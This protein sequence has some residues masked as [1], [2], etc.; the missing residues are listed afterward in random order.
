MGKATALRRGFERALAE[1]ADVVVMM[2]ADGQDDPAELPLLLARLEDGADL[3][4]GARTVRHDRFVK[5]HTS[6]LYNS[7]HRPALRRPGQGLQLRLQGDARRRRAQRRA[8]DVRRAAPLPHRRRALARLPDRRGQR[9]AP[10]A[11]ARAHQVRPG[12]LLARL[13]RP[14]HGPVPD[15]LR[16]P[17]LAPV[18]RH[19]PGQP[20]PRRRGDGLPAASRSSSGDPI[21]GRPLLIAAVVLALGGLQLVLFG[22]LA[23]LLVYS[24]QRERA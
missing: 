15:D 5:R 6:R 11:A 12:P 8:D 17:A 19:R 22:L 18:Q 4:T 9:A 24:R 20:R 21:G 14:A 1:D 16:E 10:R 13:R 2:D 3:V 7:D 23:E